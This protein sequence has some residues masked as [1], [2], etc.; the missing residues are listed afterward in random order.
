MRTLLFT[1]L[2]V[3]GS[4]AQ[5]QHTGDTLSLSTTSG[6]GS[7]VSDIFVTNASSWAVRI[8]VVPKH[9]SMEDKGS[10]F[11]MQPGTT[12]KIASYSDTASFVSPVQR[13]KVI[14]TMTT[15]K[16]KEKVIGVLMME[17]RRIDA[18]H[19]SFVYHVM[20]NGGRVGFG[21]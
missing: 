21:F 2:V 12:T 3:T 6:Q 16:G 20:G 18:H 17:D 14:G 1:T 7:Y 13:M 11:V 15:R 5:G 9:P 10:Q 19:H 8:D 4:L